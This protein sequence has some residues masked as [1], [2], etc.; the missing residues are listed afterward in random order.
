MLPLGPGGCTSAADVRGDVTKGM[1]EESDVQGAGFKV[2]VCSRTRS[3]PS[4]SV[5]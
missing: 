4:K 2:V 5:N 1:E 3:L